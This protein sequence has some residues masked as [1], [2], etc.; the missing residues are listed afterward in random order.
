MRENQNKFHIGKLKHRFLKE[1]LDNFVSS[2]HL[3]NNRVV[4]GSQIG[5]D[6]AVID[7]G[8]KYLVSKTDPITFVTD[9]IGYYAV[10]INVND[11]VCTGAIPRWFQSTILLPAGRTD[12]DLIEYIFKNIQ[13]T[14]RSLGITVIG[15]HTEITT[16]LNRPIIIGSLLGEVEKEKLVLSSGA[17][18]NDSIIL[19]K[20]IF[21]E[22][23]SIIA[24]EKETIL[25]QKGFSN[26]FIEKCKNFLY[27]PGIS[28]F[29]EA[30]TSND[31]FPITS[32]HDPTEGGLFCG[33]AELAIASEL[34]LSIKKELINILPE[35]LELSKVFEIDPYSTISS[36]SLLISINE[37]YSEDLI[38]L[39]KKNGIL[40]SKIGKFTSAKEEYFIL[41]E[42]RKK[43]PMNYTEIDEIT[44]IV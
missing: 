1:M 16:G 34:G 19:T 18:A 32:M 14:C 25:K 26:D 4:V 17:K 24:R 43:L 8:D 2:T 42:N 28:V 10:H 22:G 27:N 31:N 39:L 15:G 9:E 20:G 41:D 13:D 5:E 21:I 35:P 3:K 38:H 30:I 7:M 44:K 29:K 6:A 11:V 37:K 23:T 36:G 33:L 40:A 12:A